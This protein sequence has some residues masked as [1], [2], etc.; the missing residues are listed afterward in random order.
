MHDFLHPPPE[1]ESQTDLSK[2]LHAVSMKNYSKI[3]ALNSYTT[4]IQTIFLWL[5]LNTIILNSANDYFSS[6]NRLDEY[7]S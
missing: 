7:F 3:Q 6:T 2:K 4:F 5:K 1:C